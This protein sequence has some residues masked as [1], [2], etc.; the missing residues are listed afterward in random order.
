MPYLEKEEAIALFEDGNHSVELVRAPPSQISSFALATGLP[1]PSF[2]VP[3]TKQGSPW[4][5]F[6][7]MVSPCR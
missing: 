1:L 2:T 4:L 6:F 3:L 7:E 5:A